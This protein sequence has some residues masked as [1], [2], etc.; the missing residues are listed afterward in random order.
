MYSLPGSQETATTWPGWTLAPKPTM[1]SA[2]R[3]SMASSIR[4]TLREVCRVVE[5]AEQPRPVRQR[6]QAGDGAVV[7]VHERERAAAGRLP[8]H[9]ADH[10][11]VHDRRNADVGTGVG[12]DR[13][14][15][16]AHALGERGHRLGAGDHV[17]ALLRYGLQ[18]DGITLGDTDAELPALPLAKR[19]LAQ[20]GH[21]DG[22]EPGAR[23]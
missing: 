20:V 13:L 5:A 4:P 18:R 11:A 2:K 22:A 19:D 21:D 14:D 7:G 23:R 10:A 15:A 12:D 8:A 1:T 9:L 17:P 16:R 6:D 3:R